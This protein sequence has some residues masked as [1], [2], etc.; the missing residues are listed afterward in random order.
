MGQEK[1]A[2]GTWVENPTEKDR[3][4]FVKEG[5]RKQREWEAEQMKT[6]Q[7]GQ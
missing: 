2:E 3:A 1:K 5:A 4:H 6:G 7:G